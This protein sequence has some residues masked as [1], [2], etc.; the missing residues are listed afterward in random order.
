MKTYEQCLQEWR[1]SIELEKRLRDERK[2]NSEDIREKLI[3]SKRF[4]KGE[5]T[6]EEEA[7]MDEYKRKSNEIKEQ[8]F[9]WKTEHKIKL[10]NVKYAMWAEC[11]PIIIEV[12]GKY[13]G[14]QYGPKTKKKIGQEIFEKTGERFKCCV[15]VGSQ[16][17]YGSITIYAVDYP[18]NVTIDIPAYPTL[19]AGNTIEELTEDNLKFRGVRWE[20][21][22]D[23][24]KAALELIEQHRKVQAAMDVLCSEAS[25]YKAM[26]VGGM[27]KLPDYQQLNDYDM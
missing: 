3:K 5:T 11:V 4:T 16:Y 6:P 20:L 10:H 24:R 21:I 12:Y 8:L 25:K 26:S 23:T 15:T 19:F 2:R 22:E 13:V 9:I 7:L 14:K 1:E 27:Q 18:Y 17:T